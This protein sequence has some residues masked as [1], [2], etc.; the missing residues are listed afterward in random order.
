VDGRADIYAL[1]A[2]LFTLIAGRTPFEG[3]TAQKLM[4]HQLKSAPQLS[5]ADK[6]VPAEL[7]LAVAKMLAKTPADRFQTAAEVI[8]ALAPW[9]ANS[10]RVLA[11]L[12]RTKLGESNDVHATLAAWTLPGS[13]Q[14]LRDAAAGP[15]DPSA[16]D[17]AEEAVNTLAMSASDTPR[18]RTPTPIARPSP[19]PGSGPK[20]TTRA[21]APAP[22]GRRTLLVAL[23]LP[24]AILVAGIL[25][26][27]LA[28]GR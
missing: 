19:L 21:A 26:G 7:S 17:L 18:T 12:S 11:G 3:S 22:P 2:T 13:S 27:W 9:T 24:L 1:G 14:R 6:T 23:G 16:F 25:I 5:A 8:A 15:T 20:K 28:F 10:S 4:Q